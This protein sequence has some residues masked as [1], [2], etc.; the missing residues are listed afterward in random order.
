VSPDVTPNLR[1]HLPAYRPAT[2]RIHQ[3]RPDSPE[4]IV[5]NPEQIQ[6]S[7]REAAEIC[8]FLFFTL[9]EMK[10]E[11]VEN[12]QESFLV[13]FALEGFAEPEGWPGFELAGALARRFWRQG[14]ATEAGRAALG[15]AFHVL[16]KERVISLVAPDNH[17]SI[18]TVERLGERLESRIQHFGQEMLCFGI[19]RESYVDG[20]LERLDPRGS[21][22]LGCPEAAE[23]PGDS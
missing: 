3:L 22:P 9:A 4:L 17:A 15:Y 13:R 7:D 2:R 12:I 19:D 23:A 16:K 5:T 21:E 18:R 14:Y 11:E 8:R 1:E 6:L 20:G 10:S